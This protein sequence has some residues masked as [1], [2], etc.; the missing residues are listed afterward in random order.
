MVRT[1]RDVV[2]RR[3]EGGREAEEGEREVYV[4]SA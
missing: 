2:W 4:L 3:R 1:V